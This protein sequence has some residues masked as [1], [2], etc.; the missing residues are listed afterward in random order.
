MFRHL[1]ERSYLSF[2]MR[3][4]YCSLPGLRIHFLKLLVISNLF[5]LQA[6]VQTQAQHFAHVAASLYHTTAKI[7]GHT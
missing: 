3:Y 4:L 1:Y 7:Y 6:D 5:Y 2:S